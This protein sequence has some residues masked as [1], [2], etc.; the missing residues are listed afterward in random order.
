[1]SK[2]SW[3]TALT[4]KLNE[5]EIQTYVDIWM[6]MKSY[7]N[8]KEK[9]TAC[10]KFLDIINENVCDLSETADEWVGY[11]STLDRVLREVYI[12]SDSYEDY[13]SEDEDKW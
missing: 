12:D 2:T 13:D 10:E 1:M 9:E 5:S 8:P 6:S 3:R 11:D 7:L 4:M